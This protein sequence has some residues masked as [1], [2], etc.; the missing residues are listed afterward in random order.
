MR[1][2]VKTGG[3]LGRYLPPGGARN[4]AHLDV[5]E[6]ATPIDVMKRLG[7]PETRTYLVVLNGTLVP[8]AERERRP[9]AE[10][11]E[12]SILPPLKGG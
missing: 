11:D 4:Q 3:I 8:K 12:L 1:I 5:E 10:N 6:G 2:T 7:L 9:L